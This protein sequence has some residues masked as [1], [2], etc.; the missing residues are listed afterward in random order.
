MCG[1]FAKCLLYVVN[2]AP[3]T[4]P[5]EIKAAYH[6]ALL[7]THPDKNNTSQPTPD[8]A[9]IKDAYRVLS[10]PALRAKAKAHQ[11]PHLAQ[12]ISLADFAEQGANAWT[13]A[14]RCGSAYAITG[15]RDGPRGASRSMHQLL[16]GCVGG[17]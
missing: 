6:H 7:A 16:G 15:G 13:H 3:G 12:V 1:D 14:C 11:D 8:I 10:S 4:S 9:T 5:A 2:L 17:L